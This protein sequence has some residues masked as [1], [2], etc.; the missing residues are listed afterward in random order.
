MT[1]QA[2]GQAAGLYF[3]FSGAAKQELPGLSFGNG[4]GDYDANA[5]SPG[6]A[7]KAWLAVVPTINNHAGWQT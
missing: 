1:R 2:P 6:H 7:V 4:R 5:K 3:Y